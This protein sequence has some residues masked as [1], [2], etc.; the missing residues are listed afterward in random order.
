MAR[1]YAAELALVL[2]FLH[3]REGMAYRDLKPENI[4]L[5][6]DG[7]LKLVDFGFAKKLDGSRCSMRRLASVLSSLTCRSPRIHLDALRHT[8]R[9]KSSTFRT[10][11]CI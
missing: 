5:D 4:L 8:G 3:E 1:F 9:I 2:Q 10:R 6:G 11:G 7:H